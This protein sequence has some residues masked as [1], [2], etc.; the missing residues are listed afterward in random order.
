MNKRWKK[1]L[2]GLCVVF[3]LVLECIDTYA[4]DLEHIDEKKEELGLSKVK[5]YEMNAVLDQLNIKFW[6]YPPYAFDE[7]HF[8]VDEPMGEY[9]AEELKKYTDEELEIIIEYGCGIYGVA[10]G[11][12]DL[13]QIIRIYDNDKLVVFRYYIW[14]F[15][16]EVIGGKE[17]YTDEKY[18]GSAP[19][20]EVEADHITEAQDTDSERMEE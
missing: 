8:P 15:G 3:T 17:S 1:V 18:C 13:I 12:D 14:C 4:M 11:V 9:S 16:K 10:K 19:E 2:T 5:Q 6:N 7:K 20:W